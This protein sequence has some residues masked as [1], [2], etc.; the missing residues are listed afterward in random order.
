M[1]WK[2]LYLLDDLNKAKG[3]FEKVLDVGSRNI[4]GS[5]RDVLP[6]VD[7]TGIDFI[8]CRDVDVVMNAHHILRKFGYHK[9]DLVTC[10][11]TLEHD[12]AFWMTV[13]QMRQVVKPGGY[14]FISTPGI[15]FFKHDYPSDYWR[16]TED[17]YKDVFFKGW[18]DVHIENYSDSHSELENKPN[19]IIGWARKPNE[20]TN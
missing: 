8:K 18:M 20:E 17:A 2:I 1:F 7:I 16:F 11:E 4:N 3:P 14:L 12:D 5:V 10:C 9:F 6:G 13:Q 19:T 15:N